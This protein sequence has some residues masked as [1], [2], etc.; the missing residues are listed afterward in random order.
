MSGARTGGRWWRRLVYSTPGPFLHNWRARG[1]FALVSVLLIVLGDWLSRNVLIEPPT[2]WYA[3]VQLRRLDKAQ[4]SVTRLVRVNDESYQR[5]FG[6][7]SP[8]DGPS[9]VGAACALASRGAAVVVVDLDTSSPSRYPEGF[10]LPASP[11]PIVWAVDARRSS[12]AE[13][14][15]YLEAGMV[16]GGRLPTQPRYGVA[17]M[18]LDFDGVVRRWEPFSLVDGHWR[19][20]LPQAGLAAYCES[21][22]ADCTR[23]ASPPV[24]TRDRAPAESI[25][26]SRDIA[27]RHLSLMEFMSEPV[28]AF[29]TDCGSHDPD[30]R[31][32]GRVVVLGGS[33]SPTDRH[34]TSWGTRHGAELVASAIEQAWHSPV[35]H[36]VSGPARW[37]LELL[38]GLAIATLHH[39]VRPLAATFLTIVALPFAIVGMGELLFLLGSYEVGVIAFALG[40]LIE[41]LVTG[42]ERAES[43]ANK[44]EA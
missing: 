11:V 15:P 26:F 16:L 32:A 9:V 1:R 37:L 39:Y 13:G 35:M 33:Y 4:E 18:P 3:D 2:T 31:L 28:G 36:D 14:R 44:A 10:E 24:P 23:W 34:Y 21:N 27:F 38:L 7:Q 20:T 43:L 6:G 42:A 5:I 22:N 12:D 19:P 8:L 30:P 17:Q 25:A 29:P 40:I 41:Q